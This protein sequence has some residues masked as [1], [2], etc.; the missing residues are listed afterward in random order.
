MSKF[1]SFNINGIRS[2]PHQLQALKER[3]D[4]DVI[5][6]QESKVADE[7]FP[8]EMIE[9]L[10]WLP[11]YHGQ[12]GHYGVALLSKEAPRALFIGSWE[13]LSRQSVTTAR[14]T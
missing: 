11:S 2:R 4:P 7:L 3:H 6:I 10:G 1:V 13:A 9:S 14:M 8:V 5:G 12:K